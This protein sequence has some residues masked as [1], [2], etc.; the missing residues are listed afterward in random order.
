MKTNILKLLTVS[1]AFS[2][3]FSACKNEESNAT[4][5]K[6]GGTALLDGYYKEVA[7]SGAK[8]ISEVFNN[9]TPGTEVV[10]QGEVMGRLSPFVDGRA[11][12]VL[13]DPTKVTPCNRIPGDQCKTPWDNCCDDPDVLKKSITTIQFLDAD[14]KVL[15]AGLK[16]YKGI[17]ELSYLTVQG[18]IADGSNADNLLITAKAFNLTDPSPFKDAEP[19]ADY[20]HHGHL[21]QGVVTEEDGVIIF[22]RHPVPMEPQKSE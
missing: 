16:G 6:T 9:P 13:G 19:A 18:T 3:C 5:S 21:E 2:L 17:K 8:H 22:N 11:M 4:T 10:V 12:V 1:V 20:S 7:P 15:K 14:G